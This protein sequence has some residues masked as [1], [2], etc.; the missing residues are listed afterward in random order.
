VFLQESFPEVAD[1]AR[2][3]PA[4]GPDF[5]SRDCSPSFICRAHLLLGPSE[6]P[7]ERLNVGFHINPLY[8]YEKFSWE[9]YSCSPIV[10]VG[11]HI[12][13]PL[14]PWHWW[15]YPLLDLNLWWQEL[16]AELPQQEPEVRFLFRALLALSLGFVGFVLLKYLVHFSP[17]FCE[18]LLPTLPYA[19]PIGIAYGLVT[20]LMSI[21]LALAMVPSWLPPTPGWL[22]FGAFYTSFYY[23]FCCTLGI[24]FY[25]CTTRHAPTSAQK[26]RLLLIALQRVL[27][28]LPI[29]FLCYWMVGLGLYS[30]IVYKA[31]AALTNAIGLVVLQGLVCWQVLQFFLVS[32]RAEIE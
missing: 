32:E 13:E 1:A 16:R 17:A 19:R 10:M 2:F 15:S 6:K 8:Y 22:L 21:R 9:L 14:K 27:Q 18:H 5:Y 20:S 24:F 29:Y 7:F 28:V 26:H 30:N 25:T 31:A 12:T 4:R 3:Q 11:Y 23:F